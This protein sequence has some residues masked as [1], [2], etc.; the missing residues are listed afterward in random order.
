MLPGCSRGN[1]FVLSV[2][3]VHLSGVWHAGDHPE[4]PPNSSRS[5]LYVPR[6]GRIVEA[7]HGRQ[8]PRQR[9]RID[10]ATHVGRL[11]HLHDAVQGGVHLG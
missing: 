6:S 9:D 1:V 10:D 8:L 4:L 7:L 2:E 5:L 3:P 11:F